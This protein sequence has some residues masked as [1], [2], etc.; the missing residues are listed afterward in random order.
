MSYSLIIFFFWE[1]KGSDYF[2]FFFFFFLGL[3]HPVYK[4]DDRRIKVNYNNY[5]KETEEI[6]V[7]G[8]PLPGEGLFQCFNRG[9]CVSPDVCSCPDGYDGFDCRTPLCRYEQRDNKVSKLE[10]V[11]C[12]N[13]GLCQRK[14]T[15]ECILSNSIMHTV[16]LEV[17]RFPLF[18]PYDAI[19]GY[20]G[21]DCSIPKCVQGFWDHECRGVAPG[22]EGCFRCANG[23]NCTAPDFCT[24]PPEW[25]GYDCN[26]PVC[27]A[28]ADSETVW[29]LQTV[30]LAKIQRFEFD[31]CQSNKK[32]FHPNLVDQSYSQWRYG[33]ELEFGQG[34]CSRPAQCTCTCW[35][36]N[37]MWDPW[38]DPLGKF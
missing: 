25:T 16:H 32:H 3:D 14:D 17:K 2:F 27:I 13:G 37:P 11:G 8:P 21:T 19:T 1:Q 7:K 22:G 26:T 4:F 34:N 15:C 38:Q 18:P 35:E 12:L 33:P 28:I 24:C 10:I 23:G 29:D 5:I 6:W 30:D 20:I 36:E 9:S 31:P